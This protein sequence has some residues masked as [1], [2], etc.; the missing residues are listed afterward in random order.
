MLDV[1]TDVCMCSMYIGRG[2]HSSLTITAMACCIL[3]ILATCYAVNLILTTR[4][5]VNLL[6][7]IFQPQ[8]WRY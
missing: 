6:F 7:L 3:G 4:Y 2:G 5:A 1:F 8:V